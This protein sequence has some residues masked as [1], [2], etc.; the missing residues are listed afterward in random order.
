ML[1]TVGEEQRIHEAWGGLHGYQVAGGYEVLVGSKGPLAERRSRRGRVVVDEV[2]GERRRRKAKARDQYVCSFSRYLSL[3][4]FQGFAVRVAAGRFLSI[5]CGL[6][7]GVGE[8]SGSI[9]SVCCCCRRRGAGRS[10]AL[11]CT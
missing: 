2:R 5:A 7:G 4:L 6:V 3:G 8:L 10:R 1:A 9:R 11:L